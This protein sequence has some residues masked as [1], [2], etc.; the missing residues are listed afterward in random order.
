MHKIIPVA[1]PWIT[2]KEIAYVTDAITN[3]WYENANDYIARFENSFKVYLGRK[4]AISLPSCTSGLHLS[5]LAL[6]IGCGDEV[7]VPDATWIASAAPVTYVGATPI[8]S[9]IDQ[10]T[11]CL[12]A[13]TVRPLITQKTKAI[14]AV[15]LYGHMPEYNELLKL[16]I[17]I[18]EDAAE[19]IGSQYKSRLSGTFGV[20]SCFS[21]HGSK[22]LTTGEG[23]MLVTDDDHVYERCMIMRDHGRF[24]GD[25]LFQNIEVGYKYKM[26]NLQAALGLAQLERVDE[27]V[28]RKREI[29]SWYKETFQDCN[30]VT[31]NPDHIDVEN[32]YWM[33][34]AIFDESIKMTK[35]EIIKKLKEN[36]ISTRPFFDPLS[37]LKAYGNA[38]DGGRAKK[39]N[40]NAYGISQSGINLPSSAALSKENVQYIKDT[41]ERITND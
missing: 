15:N 3:G 34:T 7:I 10:K 33:T 20:T 39:E 36:N 29:F 31:L 4:Y 11:W 23:G 9:D 19:S 28:E 16:G 13:E 17:P 8:F 41:L 6:G 18:I 35:L 37:S 1:G 38:L 21:F 12:S 2:E 26:S 5:L 22:T 25:T 14:I 24:P 40:E 27:L 32:S 30:F